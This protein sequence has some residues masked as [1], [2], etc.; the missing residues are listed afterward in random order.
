MGRNRLRNISG[1]LMHKYLHGGSAL[2]LFGVLTVL[3]LISILSMITIYFWKTSKLINDQCYSELTLSTKEACEQL[4]SNFRLDRI[5]LRMLAKVLTDEKFSSD[6]AGSYLEMYDVNSPISSV[7]ILTSK[8]KIILKNGEAI[9]N[10]GLMSYKDEIIYGDHITA[11]KPSVLGSGMVIRSFVPIRRNGKSVGML[12]AEMNPSSIAK[13]WSPK[14]YDGACSF[15]I[16]DRYTSN[17][18]VASGPECSALIDSGDTEL[19]NTILGGGTGFRTVNV[20]MP[21][22]KG[23]PTTYFASYKPLELEK[24]EMLVMVSEED[25]FES[26]QSLS[27]SLYLLLICMG[28]LF[29]LYLVLMVIAYRHSVERAEV[30]ANVDV[31]TGLRNRNLFEQFCLSYEDSTNGL[32]CIYIDANGLHELNNTRGHLAGDQMLRFVADALKVEFGEE[33]VFRVGGD[34]FIVFCRNRGEAVLYSSMKS[35][36]SEIERNNY[37]ISAGLGAGAVGIGIKALVKVAE[38]EMYEEK[39]RYYERIGAEMRNKKEDPDGEGH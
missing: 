22:E 14:I 19:M 38:E 35:L 17:I 31:L 15:C 10:E 33:T 16:I 12:F 6:K 37:H 8:D 34:E 9:K 4:E 32:V 5:N 27:S 25:V 13:L 21:G 24:W 11:L 36:Y 28:S 2:K 26:T 18:I 23:K 20:K 1:K 30:R 29:V 39:K 7:G 3:L